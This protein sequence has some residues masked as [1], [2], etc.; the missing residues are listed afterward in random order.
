MSDFEREPWIGDARRLLDDS[1]R[2]LDAASLSRLNRARHAALASAP[3]RAAGVG[4]FA[5]AG[6]AATAVL[7]LA[8]A[9]QPSPPRTRATAGAAPA[10]GTAA[11]ATAVAAPA[12][13][14]A[15]A[16]ADAS[17]ADDSDEFYQDLEFYAWLDAEEGDG[18]G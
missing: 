1:A 15:P 17:A 7:L 18:D 8:I 11:A 13:P 14:A 4:W 6:L 5:A 12:P 9:L 16:A 3:R 10:T 2:G